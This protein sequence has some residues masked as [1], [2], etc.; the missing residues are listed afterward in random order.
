VAET[1]ARAERLNQAA[2][3]R[4]PHSAS[5]TWMISVRFRLADQ[6]PLVS[7]QSVEEVL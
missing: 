5:D 4:S 1:E 7:K 6:K 2:T 3:S